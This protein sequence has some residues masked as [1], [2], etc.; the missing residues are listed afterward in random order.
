MRDL[1]N[2]TAL[3]TSGCA[4]PL[5]VDLETNFDFV[6]VFEGTDDSGAPL[7]PPISGQPAQ[8]AAMVSPSTRR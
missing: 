6:S 7:Q 1:S 3:T 4:A 2:K 5:Q 8:I